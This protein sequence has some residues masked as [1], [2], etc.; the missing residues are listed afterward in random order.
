MTA[1]AVGGTI[2]IKATAN[3]VVTEMNKAEKKE[4]LSSKDIIIE[5]SD[6]VIATNETKA[7]ELLKAGRNVQLLAYAESRYTISTYVK[8]LATITNLPESVVYGTEPI[9]LAFNMENVTAAI[10]GSSSDVA[11]LATEEQS[12]KLTILKPGTVTLNLTVSDND[13]AA[14]TQTLK[15]TKK[16]LTVSGITATARDYNGGTDITL[17]TDQM[18]V[19]GLVGDDTGANILNTPTGKLSSANAGDA[20]P[21]EVTAT[22][23]S[24]NDYYDLAEITGVTAKIN[25]VALTVTATKPSAINFG[26]E[27]PTFGATASGFVNGENSE[28]LGGKLEFDCPATTT[29]LAGE[30]SVTPF[31]YTSQNYTITYK[32]AQLK[33]NRSKCFCYR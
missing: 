29:S 10:D 28:A 26:A 15:V 30:Y 17:V 24:K 13:D 8:T 9:T 19:N 25:K 2:Q 20:V 11:S 31:G 14:N 23:K 6:A 16:M 27:I 33:I 12:Q 4:D 22:L 1:I 3:E 21:V 7:K 18:V 5:C 32:A